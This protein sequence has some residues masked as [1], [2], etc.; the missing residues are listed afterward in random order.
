MKAIVVTKSGSYRGLQLA[1]EEIPTPKD[2]EVLVKV[3]AASIN[4]ADS[5]TI[6]MMRWGLSKLKIPGS[7]VSGTVEVVGN[8]VKQFKPGDEIYGELGVACG[9]GYAEYVAATENT[10]ALK[11]KNLSFEEAAVVPM[12]GLTA[13]QGL[14]DHGKIH[15]GQKVLIQGASG[16][17]GTF[18]VQIAKSFG[19]EVTGVCS[20]K[21]LDLVRSLG[22]DHVIDYTTEDFTKN[23]Q[24]YDLILAIKGYHPIRAYKRALSPQG[25]YVMAGGKMGQIFQGMVI[26]PRLSEPGGKKLCGFGAKSSQKDL[27]FLRELIEAGKVKPVIDRSYPLSEIAEAFK[28][29]DQGHVR[30]KVAITVKENHKTQGE[31][32][33]CHAPTNS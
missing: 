2:N 23:G 30:G 10:L 11:P 26:G 12:A 33:V 17:I 22:A 7:D 5:F 29:L 8:N 9:G 20:T 3:H 13:L 14:R 25:I 18:A 1:E 31:K 28:Y 4:F 32:T 15:A 6:R 24:G 27:D 19:T 21:N 16:G